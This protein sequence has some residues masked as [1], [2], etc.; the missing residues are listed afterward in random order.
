LH[1]FGVDPL[2]RHLVFLSIKPRQQYLL[3]SGQLYQIRN[4]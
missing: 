2:P 3:F 1:P 4:M